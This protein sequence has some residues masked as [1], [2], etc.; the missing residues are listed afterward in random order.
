MADRAPA[1]GRGDRS[2]CAVGTGMNAPRLMTT[3]RVVVVVPGSGYLGSST[4][5]PYSAAQL[6]EA[7]VYV[8]R[9]V[10]IHLGR[11]L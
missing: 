3:K 6:R 9:S 2:E 1:R 8:V 11:L 10:G 7:T 5:E 4:S